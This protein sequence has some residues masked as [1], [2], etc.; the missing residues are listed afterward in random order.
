MCAFLL[1]SSNKLRSLTIVQNVTF[2]S[3]VCIRIC[4]FRPDCYKDRK[5][6]TSYVVLLDYHRPWVRIDDSA[7]RKVQYVRISRSSLLLLCNVSHFVLELKEFC[8]SSSQRSVLAVFSK[9]VQEF[10][11]THLLSPS[12]AFQPSSNSNYKLTR[13]FL[14]RRR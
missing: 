11:L 1:L 10:Y 7:G 2:L 14:T 9:Y 6:E 12:N 4:D 8:T 3:W 5:V 13:P